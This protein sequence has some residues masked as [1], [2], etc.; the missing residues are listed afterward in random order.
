MP[1]KS[2]TA[3]FGKDASLLKTCQRKE[4][5]TLLSEWLDSAPDIEMKEDTIGLGSYGRVLTVLFSEEPVPDEED[6]Y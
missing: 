3:D 1:P 2:C 5:Y 4:S 6:D